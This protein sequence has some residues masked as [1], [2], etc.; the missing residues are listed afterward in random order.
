MYP[1]SSD[2][3]QFG[4]FCPGVTKALRLSVIAVASRWIAASTVCVHMG[5]YT[6]AVSGVAAA[7]RRIIPV[8]LSRVWTQSAA[9]QISFSFWFSF[10]DPIS[11]SNASRDDS[12]STF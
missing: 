7:F 5:Q 1:A 9:K 10:L 8:L 4:H 2:A 3:E 11:I 12:R 6:F